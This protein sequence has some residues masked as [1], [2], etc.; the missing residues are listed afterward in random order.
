MRYSPEKFNIIKSNFVIL[1]L[2]HLYEVESFVWRQKFRWEAKVMHFWAFGVGC[3]W[4]NAALPLNF[5]VIGT[6][7]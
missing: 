6:Q 5:R 3:V 4:D 7:L 2:W 1:Y